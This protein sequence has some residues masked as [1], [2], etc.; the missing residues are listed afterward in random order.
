VQK[1]QK[2]LQYIAKYCK[3]GIVISIR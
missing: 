2:G 1:N 3:L